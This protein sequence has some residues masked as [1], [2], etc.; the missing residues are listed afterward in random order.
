MSNELFQESIMT[1]TIILRDKGIDRTYT[2]QTR[3]DAIVLFEALTA[4]HTS[5]E[6]WLD[7]ERIYHF[8]N[9]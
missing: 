7:M 5:V 6:V 8:N 3:F 4:K 1:Y 2:A 9:Q